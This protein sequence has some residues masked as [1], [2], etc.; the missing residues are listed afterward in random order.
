M[1]AVEPYFQR[2]L[3]LATINS[4][5]KKKKKKSFKPGLSCLKELPTNTLSEL[6]FFLSSSGNYNHKLPCFLSCV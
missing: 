2:L 6:H 1:E 5:L 4:V 3:K